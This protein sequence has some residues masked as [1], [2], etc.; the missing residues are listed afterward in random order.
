MA[1]A[2]KPPLSRGS[3]GSGVATVQ[4]LL[5]ALGH[6]MPQTVTTGRADGIFGLETEAAVRK[7]QM[8]K[9]LQVDGQ[10]GPRTLDALDSV[11]GK[12]P[13]LE[14]DDRIPDGRKGYW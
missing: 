3:T 8:R 2:N 4:E 14:R 11:I 13:R 7:F 9:G 12:N 1:S 10:V 6:V 5:Y